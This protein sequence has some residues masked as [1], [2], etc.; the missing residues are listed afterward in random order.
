ETGSTTDLEVSLPAL[1]IRT[2][3]APYP[4][5]VIP[6][7]LAREG[8]LEPIVTGIHLTGV[9]EEAE[10]AIEKALQRVH[11]DTD[12]SIERGPQSKEW[13]L[14]LWVVAAAGAVLMLAGTLTAT[15]LALSDARADL[16]TLSAVG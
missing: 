5:A 2:D 13:Q 10:R 3:E 4:N 9:D 8:G 14:V 11:Y 1:L 16:A 12:V 7:E 15:F 6:E